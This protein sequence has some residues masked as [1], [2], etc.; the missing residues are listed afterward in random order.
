MAGL[1]ELMLKQLSKQD[2]YDFK[3]RALI[4]VLVFAGTLRRQAKKQALSQKRISKNT[5]MD[6]Q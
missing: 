2:H 6:D 3:L 1:Y 4:S 5:D